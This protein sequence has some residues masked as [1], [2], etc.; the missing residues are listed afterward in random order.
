MDLNDFVNTSNDDSNYISVAFETFGGR[1]YNNACKNG[2]NLMTV[3]TLKCR[4][5]A[6]VMNLLGISWDMLKNIALNYT[7]VHPQV[8]QELFRL[9]PNDDKIEYIVSQDFIRNNE[10]FSIM[11]KLNRNERDKLAAVDG[12]VGVDSSSGP[13]FDFKRYS[14]NLSYALDGS[15]GFFNNDNDGGVKRT[16]VQAVRRMYCEM[17]RYISAE[18]LSPYVYRVLRQVCEEL[19]GPTLPKIENEPQISDD[20]LLGCKNL[21][22]ETMGQVEAR[23][24]MENIKVKVHKKDN[25]PT[26]HMSKKR[27]RMERVTDQETN[28]C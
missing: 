20:V 18:R 8:A 17:H 10:L 7:P 2:N 27:K 3:Q 16:H 5:I 26:A 19:G 24:F 11:K 25:E 28:K 14:E 12:L 1:I 22:V 23:K 15:P 4:T 9:S 21:Y 13:N 6:Y